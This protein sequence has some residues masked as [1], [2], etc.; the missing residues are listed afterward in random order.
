MKDWK[1]IKF[2][3]HFKDINTTSVMTYGEA[4]NGCDNID[5]FTAKRVIEKLQKECDYEILNWKVV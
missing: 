4:I 2:I 1:N 5:I 3:I